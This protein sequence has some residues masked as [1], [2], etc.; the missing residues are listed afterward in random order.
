MDDAPEIPGSHVAQDG[1]EHCDTCV[2]ARRS[3]ILA[4][5]RVVSAALGLTAAEARGLTVRTVRA[6]AALASE[7]TY[8]LPSADGVAIDQANKIML[9]RWQS[10]VYA[11]S[12]LC[13]HQQAPLRWV[14]DGFTCTKHHSQFTAPGVYESGRSTR[15]IDRHQIRRS[16]DSVV[17]NA[18]V[19]YRDDTAAQ[20]WS[21]AFISL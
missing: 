21:V 13:P 18:A 15:N 6:V 14:A 16:G 9:V 1:E 7:V 8:P 4:T 20:Q 5:A 17:V 11:L 3:F 2:I 19:L 10:R 12:S